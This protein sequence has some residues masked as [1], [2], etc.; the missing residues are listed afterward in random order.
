MKFLKKFAVQILQQGT[1]KKNIVGYPQLI[2]YGGFELMSYQ[3]NS[4]QL[5]VFTALDGAL[6]VKDLRAWIEA[7][8]F[9]VDIGPVFKNLT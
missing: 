4:R 7:S 2:D 6:S 1:M 8:Q 9:K 5:I 3:S